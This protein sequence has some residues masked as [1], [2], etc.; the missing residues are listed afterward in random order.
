MGVLEQGRNDAAETKKKQ[1][2]KT[3]KQTNKQTKM[4]VVVDI[5]FVQ[6]LT[7]V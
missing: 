4:R 2:K 1:K 7:K 6:K 5:I 3:N